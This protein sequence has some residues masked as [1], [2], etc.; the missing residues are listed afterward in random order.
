M[1]ERNIPQQDRQAAQASDDH[2]KSVAGGPAAEIEKAEQL[3]RHRRARVATL[4][5]RRRSA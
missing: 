1:S 3:L 5:S 2:I 4:S